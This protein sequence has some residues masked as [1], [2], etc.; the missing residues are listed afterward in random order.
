MSPRLATALIAAGTLISLCTAGASG[1]GPVTIPI[2]PVQMALFPTVTP[3]RLSRVEAT[4]AALAIDGR[5]RTFD[6]SRPPALRE[7][8]LDLD[9]HIAIDTRGLPSCQGGQRDI[10]PP[11]LKSYCKGAIV[12]GGRVGFQLQFSGQPPVS[13]ESKLT[14]VNDSQEAGRTTLY[15]LAFL[16]QPIATAVTMTI[17]ITRQ[18]QGNRVII[19]VPEVANGAGS[20]THLHIKL[21][22]RFT[23]NGEAVDLL[24]GR[25]PD[26]KMQSSI[27]TTFEDGTI[28]QGDALQTCVPESD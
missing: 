19:E 9:R 24:T 1:A 16:I 14:I 17:P 4:P 3:K 5:I 22:K 11:D 13:S 23:R 28:L 18:A 10:R 12:G 7:V 2:V 26:G 8:V 25:C 15:G 27:E 20:L 21:K 6:G